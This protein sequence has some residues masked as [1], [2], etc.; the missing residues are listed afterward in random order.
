MTVIDDFEARHVPFEQCWN[1]RDIGGY[2]ATDGG[3]LA[4][5]RYYRSGA[6]EDMHAADRARLR[7]LG[8]RT[9][10]DLRRPE[11]TV[12]LGHRGVHPAAELGARYAHLPPLPD[13]ASAELDARFGRAISGARYLG[14]LDY[15]GPSLRAIF[16]VLADPA[17]Y[18]LIVHCT[19]GKDRT[20][21][22]TAMAL[23]L[24]GVERG[25]I[26]AD[27]ELTNRDTERW[28]TWS[29]AN[30]H[31]EA[32]G[33]PDEERRRF[34]VPA[35][36]IGTFLDGLDERYGGVRGYLGSLG[37]SEDIFAAI[38]RNLLASASPATASDALPAR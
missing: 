14:Y 35:E 3:V 7:A 15:A 8:V 31:Y 20:G 38:R 5:Q 12:N 6:L 19:A 28:L 25:V 30:G 32:R 36:A 24:A 9:I 33:N 16:E 37:L 27:F 4:W 29:V 1:F 13:G 11:E 17:S 2:P 26:E 10:V 23:D 34:G 21:V 22:T 18:P